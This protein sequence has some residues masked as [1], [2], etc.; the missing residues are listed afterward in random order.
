MGMGVSG[1]YVFRIKNEL[2]NLLIIVC[3]AIEGG[4]IGVVGSIP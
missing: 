3:V 1:A 2:P 4:W